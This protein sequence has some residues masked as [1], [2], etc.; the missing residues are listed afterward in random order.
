MYMYLTGTS[1]QLWSSDSSASKSDLTTHDTSPRLRR[2]SI[3][4]EPHTRPFTTCPLTRT[5]VRVYFRHESSPY[6]SSPEV[7]YRMYL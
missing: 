7:A 3:A 1:C 2:L 4:R 5:A 6:F